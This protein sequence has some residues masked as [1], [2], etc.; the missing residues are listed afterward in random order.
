MDN[1]IDTI[2][3][4][5]LNNFKGYRASEDGG[6]KEL[7][8]TI[9]GQPADLI[10]VTGKNGVGKTSLLEAMDWVLNQSDVGAGGFITTGQRDGVVS[11]NSKE[12]E[13]QGKAKPDHKN[14]STVA[15]FFFQENITGLACDEIIQLL[16]PEN[17][18]G[19]AIK[20]SLKALQAKLE[21]WQRQLHTLKYRK[22]Y[23]EE[24][25]ALAG[26]VNELVAKLPQDLPLRQL[27]VDSTLTLKNGNL[28]NKWDSQ[29]RNLSSSIG[30]FGNL[31]E[32]V[33][34][35]L[36]D[37]LS[38]IGH[39][40][41]EYRGHQVDFSEKG[42]EPSAFTKGFLSTIQSLP[43]YLTIKKWSEDTILTPSEL[44][45]TL[46]IGSDTDIYAD[47]VD[48]LEKRRT[49][50]TYEYQ[51]LNKLQAQLQG[52]GSSLLTWIDGFADNVNNWLEAWDKHPDISDVTNL[53]QGIQVQLE[54]LSTLA[55]S[56]SVELRGKIKKVTEE[57][58]TVTARLNQVK[59]SQE[60]VRDINAHPNQL[61]HLLNGSN[62]TVEGLT[63]YVSD[64]LE[65]IKT[66][67]AE[68]AST[69]DET[70]IIHQLGR[71]FTS[72]SALEIQK[73]EDEASATD[74]DSLEQ[75]EKMITDALIISKQESGARSQLLSVVEVIPEAELEQLLRN[76][77][78]LLAS[79]HFP[80][81]FLPIELENHGT[82]KT[83]KWGFTTRSG[84]KFEDLS[85]GQKSQ[86]A[87]CWTINLNLAMSD[88]LG[89]RVIG[90]DDFTTSLDMNQLIPAA[91]LLRKLAYTDANDSWK[92][93]VIV[94]SHHEDL[95]NRL[96]D[97]LLP[98]QGK[99]M[100]VIQF[101]DWLPASGPQIKCYNV[102]MGK[103]KE[104][105]L[106]DAVKRVVQT[107]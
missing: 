70:D 3:F 84:V 61:S 13:L 43:A 20:R 46:F 83:Q 31:A 91:V 27:L 42:N 4:I 62:F 55:D 47:T 94:T 25:K 58:Q 86:L 44:E 77:N 100:K 104:D 50:L 101:E 69:V 11:I 81:D 60:V 30:S 28:Q 71:V 73:A 80:D 66:P 14:L 17:K 95:T 53:K 85:T 10:L 65:T 97:F 36:P 57:G 22:N 34:S 19:E 74:L 2:E 72:W 39:S 5:E 67:V 75:A 15:S 99:S 54:S 64:Y 51:R 26:R 23:E 88:Q 107:T 8:F 98:P 96:L 93:Q 106:Q 45:N 92:R 90:F 56:R 12:F 89:H 29:I 48:E 105:G 37:Q 21:D 79:F 24:R 68:G 9:A 52:D 7:D 103:V 38:H 35:Q 18:P 40:L 78:Q 32:L 59:R 16:E 87:I 41:L 63:D 76:M 1:K 49:E 102:D 6:A 33:G 82:L